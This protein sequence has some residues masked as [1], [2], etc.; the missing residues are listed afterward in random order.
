PAHSAAA[1]TNGFAECFPLYRNRSRLQEGGQVCPVE[2]QSILSLIRSKKY[3][4]NVFV[5]SISV[6]YSWTFRCMKEGSIRIHCPF[7]LL[8]WE[9]GLEPDSGPQGNAGI[10]KFA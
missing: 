7:I 9:H 2:K 1:R 5:G 10:W 6:F 8:Y 4:K 3:L